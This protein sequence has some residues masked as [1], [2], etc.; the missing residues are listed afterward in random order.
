MIK[1]FSDPACDAFRQTAREWLESVVPDSWQSAQDHPEDPKTTEIRR[2]WDR[3]LYSGGYA[4]LSWPT[5][6][7][8]QGLGAIEE[9]IFAEECAR[10]H[11]PQGL[12]QIGRTLVG[13][14]L[15]QRG[16]PD[17]ITRFL[18]GILTGE[19]IWCQGYSE[20][21]AGSDLAALVTTARR[22]G[23]VYR[24]FGRKIWTSFAHY[25]DW[26]LLL[27]RTNVH[28]S[29]HHNLSLLMIS[30]H[31][32]GVSFVPIRQITGESEF[33]ETV[34][35]GA[36][37][38]L[39]DRIGDEDDGWAVAMGSLTIERGPE[40]MLRRYI[41]MR[42][43]LDRLMT[44]CGSAAAREHVAALETESHVL[45]WHIFRSIELRQAEQTWFPSMAVCKVVTTELEQSVAACGVSMHCA[46]HEDYWRHRYLYSFAGTIAGG[47]NEIQRNIISERVL[48][49]P[50]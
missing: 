19:E 33:N 11:A 14:T 23:D 34:W 25:A 50:R 18:P 45:R 37:A 43:G 39:E 8:G 27:A 47:S 26:C 10:A 49:L 48:G 21:N 22:D 16:R 7:G 15:M 35:E 29:R 41:D 32:A 20:P 9:A 17:Q 42:T 4:G 40:S 1:T 12:A 13:P 44:C 6:Y 24:I 5:E 36:I 38:R 30:L 2:Q 3:T 46:T 31:Q 28:G